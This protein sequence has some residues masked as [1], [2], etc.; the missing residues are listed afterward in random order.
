MA[1]ARAEWLKYSCILRIICD[2]KFYTG[3]PAV[4]TFYISILDILA[5]SI[6]TFDENNKFKQT[7]R[8]DVLRGN[9]SIHSRVSEKMLLLDSINNRIGSRLGEL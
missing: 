4:A 6:V 2:L 1:L 7:K 3:Q 8:D 5:C 9:E